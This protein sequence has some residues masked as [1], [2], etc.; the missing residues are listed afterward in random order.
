[1]TST[2]VIVGAGPRGTGLLERLAASAPELHPD[3]LDVH[4]VDPYPPGRG[5]HLA[6]RAVAAARDELDGRRRHHVHRRLR[7]LR[8]PDRARPVVLGLGA[9]RRPRSV[10]TGRRAGPRHPHHVPQPPSAERL[11]GLGA[12]GRA[13]PAARGH[14][15]APAPHPR[16]RAH[17]GRGRHPDRAPRGSPAAARRRRRARLRAPRRHP[18]PGRARPRR[19]GRRSGPALPAAGT[20]HRH[21]PLGARP[22]RDGAG[23]RARPG[24][25]R[26]RRAALRG[27]RRPVRARRGRPALR[28]VRHRALPGGGLAARGAVPRQDPLPAARRAPTAAAL[29]RPRAG[30]PAD[31]RGRAGRH[32]DTGLAADGQGDRL[33]LV[34]RAGRAG[35]PTGSG[36]HGRSS[37]TASPRST[38]APPPWTRC[39][40]RPCPTR[41]TAS[42]SPPSTA[43]STACSADSLDALQPLVQARIAEDLRQHVDERH[44]PHLGAFVAMLSVYAEVGRL[45]DVLSVRSRAVDMGWWQSFFNS[46]ASGPPGFRVRSC[47]RSPARATCASSGRGCGSRSPTAPSGPRRR[48]IPEAVTADV[49]VDAR[50]PDPSVSRSSTRCVAALMREGS[51]SEEVLRDEHGAVLR[52]TGQLRCGPPTARSSTRPGGCTPAGSRSAAHHRAG[53]GRVHPAGHER[54]EPA[55]QRRRRPRRAARARRAVGGRR[56]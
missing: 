40:P 1:M 23:P 19:P 13:H 22:R 51:A 27:P 48:A 20:D 32:R 11:P 44:T 49:L 18:H 4:L 55:L 45:A 26:P 42:T 46:V 21:R 54:P 10:P 7:R 31:R 6:A 36:C 47:W 39:S 14:A 41:S 43:P 52:N 8:G 24:V 33:G 37:S 38:G 15:G 17:R 35:T 16:D 53:G 9:D 3:G 56:A 50:L 28:A 12:G 29:P 5:P 2:I 34:P 30:R 25:H